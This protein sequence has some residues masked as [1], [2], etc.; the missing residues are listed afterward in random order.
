MS[1]W[2]SWV[3]AAI[4]WCRQPSLGSSSWNWFAKFSPIGWRWGKENGNWENLSGTHCGL[5]WQDDLW[6]CSEK[7]I[8]WSH[9]ALQILN[10]SRLTQ[11][12]QVSTVLQRVVALAAGLVMG[13]WGA[14]WHEIAVQGLYCC[15]VLCYCTTVLQGHQMRWFLRI[16]SVTESLSI[17]YTLQHNLY[18][19]ITRHSFSG[20]TLKICW[21]LQMLVRIVMISF[22]VYQGCCYKTFRW[23]SIEHTSTFT[24]V[25]ACKYNSKSRIRFCQ[26]E[27]KFNH[28]CNAEKFIQ[29]L[30][31]FHES[32][33]NNFDSVKKVF[34]EGVVIPPFSLRVWK[35]WLRPRRWLRP[36]RA[37]FRVCQ[38]NCSFVIKSLNL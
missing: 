35:K 29:D 22:L 19:A 36:E 5:C 1:R 20:W 27:F 7:V 8:P 6:S 3:A 24:D 33:M 10:Q 12:S 9:H 30:N 4:G 17:Y 2:W 23:V 34:T 37:Y 31:I 38:Y 25:Y 14:R 18:T 28:L 11:S 16:L 13:E 32:N 21:G 26:K 15:T